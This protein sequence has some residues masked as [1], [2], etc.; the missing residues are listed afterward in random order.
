VILLRIE[1]SAKFASKLLNYSRPPLL[2]SLFA[3][4]LHICDL[5]PATACHKV[6]HKK[7]S[8]F[9]VNMA[10]DLLEIEFSDDRIFYTYRSR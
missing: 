4:S 10:H 5:S 6:Q 1:T 9:R 3:P 7:L 8:V 2:Q